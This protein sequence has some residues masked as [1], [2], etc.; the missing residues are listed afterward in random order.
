MKGTISMLLALCLLL[1][2]CSAAT[3]T[4]ENGSYQIA[5]RRNDRRALPMQRSYVDGII[6]GAMPTGMESTIKLRI[7]EYLLT[8]VAFGGTVF[9]IGE[10]AR[11][12]MSGSDIL[13]FDRQS[14]RCIA[15]GELMIES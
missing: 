12:G 14:G 2:G 15:A 7:G 11:F 3:V 8:S 6:Y 4:N 5:G 13:L 10:N 9:T 1:T